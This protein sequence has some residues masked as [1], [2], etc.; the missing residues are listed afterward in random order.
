[1][2]LAY[3]S[4]VLSDEFNVDDQIGDTVDIPTVIITKEKP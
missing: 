3:D 1:M 2:L 4:N